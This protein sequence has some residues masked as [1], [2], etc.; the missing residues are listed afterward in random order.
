M[1]RRLND[2]SKKPTT[3]ITITLT[4]DAEEWARFRDAHV[5]GN[6]VLARDNDLRDSFNARLNEVYCD[7]ADPLTSI[8]VQSV[9][10]DWRTRFNG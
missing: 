1:L 6:G 8:E 5:S 3:T 2:M 9:M 7:G 4:A 10:E